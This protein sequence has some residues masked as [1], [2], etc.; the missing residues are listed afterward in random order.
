MDFQFYYEYDLND[1]ETEEVIELFE[2]SL[3]Y[4]D[5][6]S[7]GDSPLL[8]AC[9]TLNVELVKYLLRRG[10]NPNFIN[11]CGEAPLHETINIVTH[12]EASALEIIDALLDANADLE[13]RAYM[14][15]TPFL[16]ACGRESEK[17]IKLL[18]SRG[19]NTS[20]YVEEY[21]KKLTGSFYAD[22]F[23]LSSNLRKYISSVENS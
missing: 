23:H 18:V 6:A 15:K 14:E 16:K 5:T 7:S 20:A 8:Y 9:K 17:V 11:E 12:D 21:D 3:D 10:A 2:T 13:L 19:C 4:Q 22:V 1:L